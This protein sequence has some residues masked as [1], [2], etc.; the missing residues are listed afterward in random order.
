MTF[1]EEI[2][3]RIF[4]IIGVLCLILGFCYECRLL[5]WGTFIVS[6]VEFYNILSIVYI[7]KEAH[8]DLLTS[9]EK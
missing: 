8:K 9:Q 6:C 5:Y 4:N 2:L 1:K 3:K 7:F